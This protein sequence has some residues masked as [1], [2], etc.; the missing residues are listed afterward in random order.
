MTLTR[1]PGELENGPCVQSELGAVLA[2]IDGVEYASRCGEAVTAA[3]WA[4][5]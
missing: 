5:F 3:G 1:F 4:C 2:E